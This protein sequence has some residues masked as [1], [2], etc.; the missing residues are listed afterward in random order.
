MKLALQRVPL[1]VLTALTI[2]V[3]LVVSVILVFLGVVALES[4]L[5]R[6]TLDRLPSDASA[7]YIDFNAGRMPT[8]DG[9]QAL[10]TSLPTVERQSETEGQLT[11]L[12]LAMIVAL[13]GSLFGYWLARKISRPLEVLAAATE[14][15]R[16]GDFSI[17]VGPV[18]NAAKEVALLVRRFDALA[19]ELE[20]M[21][22]RLRFNT[23]AVAHELRTPLTVLRGNLQ[24]MADGVFPIERTRIV[25]LLLQ[26]EGLS[27]LVEDLRTLSLA[28]G[29]KLVTQRL[30]LDLSIEV[31]QVLEASGHL[32]EKAGMTVEMALQPARIVGDAQRLRQAVLAL[33]EN[34]TRYAADG[35]VLR[36]EV[37]LQGQ[38]ACIRLLDRGPGLPEDVSSDSVDLFWRAD[39]SRSRAT[40]GS[41]LGLS[42]VKAIAAAHDGRLE[43]ATRPGGGAIVSIVLPL[44]ASA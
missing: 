36:C 34:A 27:A 23:M 9:V 12:A 24:G 4:T 43:F 3:L 7:A 14:N 39:T 22:S 6:R 44:E 29:Q 33:V 40:G 13:V 37:G 25:Q 16:A 31:G 8:Q 42:V 2:A 26:V 35:G 20:S 21:E 30:P 15:L 19:S 28:A 38:E 18:G 10:L 41:G 1:G 17:R 11:I 5:E 32:L